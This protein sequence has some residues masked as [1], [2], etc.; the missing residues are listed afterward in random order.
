[1][2]A[3]RATLGFPSP[4]EDFAEDTIDL[5][6]LLVRNEVAT[7]WY[8]AAGDSMRLAGIVDGDFLAVDR[9]VTPLDGDLVLAIWEGNAPACKILRIA[10]D[11]IELH[12]A[13]PDHRPIVL[14]PGQECEVFAIVSIARQIVRGNRSRVRA[15]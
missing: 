7:F 8:R 3:V 13:N 15:R 11:H 6:E 1:V 2:G 4:A 5:N 12:S 14:R 9:S 10:G